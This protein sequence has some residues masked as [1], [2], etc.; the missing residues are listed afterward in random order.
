MV[1]ID[2]SSMQGWAS[3]GGIKQRVWHLSLALFCLMAPAF[4]ACTTPS[5][6]LDDREEWSDDVEDREDEQRGHLPHPAKATAYATRVLIATRGGG[7]TAGVT[8]WPGTARL[9]TCSD[10][11]RALA[12]ES[13]S[14]EQL[15][16]AQMDLTESVG[17]DP[18]LYH[19]CFYNVMVELDQKLD[20]GGPV[21]TELA[22]EFFAGFRA[23]WIL[24][25]SLDAVTGKTTY[26]D[27]VRKRYVQVSKDY[28]GRDLEIYA[29]AFRL[30]TP[31]S[32]AA[33]MPGKPAGPAPF[34]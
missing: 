9:G 32:Q 19:F 34:N 1:G 6:Q 13:T 12:R 24:G 30:D 21:M 5:S 7:R 20:E 18:T 29:P 4:S 3:R 17:Q 27:Y 11:I 31:A 8:S 33:P 22:S 23:L 26:F 2:N 10:E 15:M 14:Q 16:R 28:F 25:R